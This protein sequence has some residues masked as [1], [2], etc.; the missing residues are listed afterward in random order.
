MYVG[1]DGRVLVSLWALTSSVKAM[2]GVCGFHVYSCVERLVRLFHEDIE[3]RHGSVDAVLYGEVEAG[4][5]LEAML[6]LFCVVLA[7]RFDEYIDNVPAVYLRLLRFFE[8]V[9]FYAAHEEVG[10]QYSKG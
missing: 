8:D 6:K 10:Q 3:E 7:L 1:A 5:L 4:C 9:F 2:S